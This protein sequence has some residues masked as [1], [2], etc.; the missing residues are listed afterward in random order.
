MMGRAILWT[1]CTHTATHRFV[2]QYYYYM[3]VGVYIYPPSPTTVYAACHISNGRHPIARNYK[4]RTEQTERECWSEKFIADNKIER[5]FNQ[6]P[7][8]ASWRTA[9]GIALEHLTQD[10]WWWI[11][12]SVHHLD[13]F[14]N[15][16]KYYERSCRRGFRVH[17]K[18]LN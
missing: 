13:V 10:E 18:V 5:T 8:A 9:H 12:L 14:K 2:D 17:F 15:G 16:F 1:H 4:N 7:A 6:Q 11:I 3:V